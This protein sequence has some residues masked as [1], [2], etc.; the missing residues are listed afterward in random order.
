MNKIKVNK[1]YKMFLIGTLLVIYGTTYAQT[2]TLKI[3]H[4]SDIHTVFSL[5]NCNPI[6]YNL[7]KH[8]IGASDSL[9]NFFAT[10]PQKTNASAVVITGDLIDYFKADDINGNKIGNQVEQFATLSENCPVPLYLTLGNHCLTSYGINK[11][12]SSKQQTQIYADKARADFVRNFSCFKHGTYYKKEIQV[13]KTKYHLF[14]LDN[15]N[16]IPSDWINKTQLAWFKNEIEKVGNEPVVIFQHKYFLVGD[17]NGD[18]IYFKK[19][20]PTD[21]PKE[22]NCSEGFMKVLNEHKNIKAIFLGHGHKNTWE[23]IKFPSGHIIYQIE[24]STLYNK[25]S[26]WRL[27][28]FTED[29]MIVNKAGTTEIELKVK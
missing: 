18:G 21:W 13:G 17:I 22:E 28:K 29:A 12:D 6:F 3:I 10:V 19:N 4:T 15:G 11:K 2:D 24:T 8:L 20:K 25:S 16:S 1:L 7:R 26:N 23:G 27:I 14:F 9:K 5:D